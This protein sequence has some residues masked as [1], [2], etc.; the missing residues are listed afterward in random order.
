MDKA[1]AVQSVKSY[2][3][4][5]LLHLRQGDPLNLCNFST[6]INWNATQL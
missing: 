5:F 1:N 4:S 2:L 3:S 6:N